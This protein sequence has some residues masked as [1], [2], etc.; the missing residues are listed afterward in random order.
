M[1][2]LNK[3]SNS[4][5]CS[6]VPHMQIFI[7]F[8][9]L[10]GIKFSFFIIAVFEWKL[11]VSTLFINWRAALSNNLGEKVYTR[12]DSAQLQ[13][14]L[15]SNGN[16]LTSINSVPHIRRT[17]VSSRIE[18][19]VESCKKSFFC[20][21]AKASFINQVIADSF[22]QIY[23]ELFRTFWLSDSSTLLGMTSLMT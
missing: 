23:H 7:Y 4:G 14:T 3:S 19:L 15:L 22:Q 5:S 1:N 9:P 21:V 11:F 10:L 13:A 2:G 20:V 17:R 8:P 18:V 6:S 12:H 16:W